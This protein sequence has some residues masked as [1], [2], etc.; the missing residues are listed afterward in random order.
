MKK[1]SLYTFAILVGALTIFSCEEKDRAFPEFADIEHGA[2]PRLVEGVFGDLDF[3]YPNDPD[4]SS[5]SWTVE[6]YDDNQGRDVTEYIINGTYGAFGPT[7]IKSY[8]SFTTNSDGLPQVT[9]DMT[10]DEIF[11]AL[12]MTIDD[13]ELTK[14]FLLTCDLVTASGKVYSSSNTGSNVVGQPTFS[15]FFSYTPAV[16]KKPCN[17]ILAGTFEAKSKA[18][19]QDAGI[20]WD[21]CAGNSWTGTVRLE[22]QHDPNTFD[23]GSYIGYSINDNGEEVEDA[24][25]GTYYSCYTGSLTS[26]GSDLPLGDLRITES[27]GKLGFSGGSQ[28]GEVWSFASV[29]VDGA[30]LTVKV[31][32]DYGEGGEVELTRTDGEA[33]QIDLF[34][35]GC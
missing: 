11:T 8:T 20:G 26:D 31:V 6:M 35:D 3:E 9:I 21:D 34:C 29:E 30:T 2:Y 12:G 33:W 24:S 25:L 10:F 1:F 13:F 32:N 28:W 7:R 23:P 17:S 16:T 5:L 18:T 27:C 14:D 4:S 22:E 15:G 19:S